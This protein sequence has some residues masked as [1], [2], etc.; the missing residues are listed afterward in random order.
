MAA[1]TRKFSPRSSRGR[2]SRS[3]AW[4]SAVTTQTALT[5]TAA[6]G[7]SPVD[8]S[9]AVETALGRELID[10][11]FVRASGE[12]NLVIGATASGTFTRG[13]FGF[14]LLW[15]PADFIATGTAAS[16]VPSPFNDDYHWIWRKFRNVS[17]LA[18]STSSGADT[19]RY[20]NR[21]SVLVRRRIKQPSR[22]F[23]LWLIGEHLNS[24]IANITSVSYNSVL[25]VGMATK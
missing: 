5:L 7:P 12:I 10:A 6:T 21:I 18:S 23:S 9:A 1:F 25:Q 14:G 3:G 22:Q 19:D 17:Y 15:A 20:N 11:T 4:A 16:D 24:G 8:L 2:W 13:F